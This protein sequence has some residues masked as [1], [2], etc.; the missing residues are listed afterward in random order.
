MNTINDIY[1]SFLNTNK[2]PT[3]Q[4]PDFANSS[5]KQINKQIFY[6]CE[7]NYC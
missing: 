1:T 7:K 6:H 5:Y 4:D 3:K 2:K